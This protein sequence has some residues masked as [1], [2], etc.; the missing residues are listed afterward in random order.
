[1]FVAVPRLAPEGVVM[2]AIDSRTLL[3]SWVPPPF[4]HQKG[5][6]R[7]YRVNSTER[8]TGMA[9]RLTT[10]ATSLTGPSLHPFYTYNC[11]VAAFTIAEGPYSL[12][13][14][15]TMPEDGTFSLPLI[16][17]TTYISCH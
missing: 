13:V 11:T 12:E 9:Y 8:E 6:I 1:M 15:I 14:N 10:A 3:I 5:I 4:E 2:T 16:F 7:E 17:I